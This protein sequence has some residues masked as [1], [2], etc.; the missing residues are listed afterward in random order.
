MEPDRK[1]ILNAEQ[2]SAAYCAGNA[3]V[4]AGAGSGKTM[5]LA[6]RYSWLVTERKIRV[7]EILA[8][9]FTKKAAAQMH[10]RIYLE[11]AEAARE[12]GG[13]KA[14]L[15]SRAL[16][17]F[18]QARI[19]T[20][21]SYCASIVR[22]A[23][24]RYGIRPDF[25]IDNER[26]QQL[27]LD[28]SLP[29]VIANR[30]HSAMER[31]YMRKSPMGIAKSIF[32]LA[33]SKC[34]C[35]G[36]S[37]G[38]PKKDVRAQFAAI[39]REWKRQSGA[40]MEKLDALAGA[41]QGNK[42]YH[43]DIGPILRQYEEG[44]AV[45]PGEKDLCAFFGQLAEAPHES[46][47]EWAESQPLRGAMIGLCH[48]LASLNDLPLTKGQRS[49]NP[50]KDLLKEFRLLFPG[51]SA[52]IVFCLQAG[53]IYSVLMLF[54]D[55]RRR[56]AAKKRAAGI[57]TFGDVAGL[58]GTILL[59]QPDIR[60]SEKEAFRAI[61]I[62][63]FQDNNALQKDLL[64]FLAEK[65]GV[66]GS[67][68]P[69]AGDLSPGKLFFVGDEKQSIYLFRGADVSVFRKLKD[70]LGGMELHLK[71]NYRSAPR[72]I[73][74]FN[75]IFGGCEFDPLGKSAAPAG[76][77][78]VFAPA[79][80]GLPS[81]EAAYAPL[82]AFKTQGG[83]L[84]LCILDKPG[85]E[86]GGARSA[87]S[88][89]GAAGENLGLLSPL[90]SEA[91]YVA[92]KIRALLEEKDES[93]GRKYMPGDIAILFRAR[94]PQPLFEKHLMLLG[95]PY[96]SEELNGFFYGGPVND[97]M[98]VLR[99]AAYPTDRLAYAQMLRSPFAGLSLQG[100]AACL[101]ACGGGA[102]EG[103]SACGSACGSAGGG[104]GGEGIPGPFGEEP[105]A[106]LGG[107]DREKYRSGQRIYRKILEMACSQSIS[108]LVSELWFGEGYRYETEWHPQ[109]AAFREMYDYLFHLAAQADES[110]AAGSAP[111]LSGLAAFTDYIQQLEQSSERLSDIGIPLER[112]SA[113]HLMTI[114]KSKG[115]EFPVVFLCCCDRSGRGN[116]SDDIFGAESGLTLN[117]PLPAECEGIK[118]IRRNYFWERSLA[119]EREKATAELR[120]LLYVGMTR[121][122]SELYLSGCLDLGKGGDGGQESAGES[123]ADFSGR[124]KRYISAQAQ[125]AAKSGAGDAIIDDGTFFGLCL[126]AL[127]ARIPEEGPGAGAA[128]FELEEIP[129]FAERDILSA[130][131]LGSR[132]SNDQKGLNGFFEA[133]RHY[134]GSASVLA[135]PHVAG[136]HF[137][138]TA[139]SMESAAGEMPPGSFAA[140]ARYSGANAFDVFAGVDR[141]LE[142]H[143][144]KRGEDG[145][146]FN[147]GS[148]GTIAH[149]CVEAHLDGKKAA[150]PP[151]LAGFLTI[152]EARAFLEAGRELASRFVLS[153]LGIIAKKSAGRKSEFPFRSLVRAGEG[154]FFFVNGVIDL[155]FEDAEA[156][157][158]VDF[159][160]DSSENPREHIAQMA[161]YYKAASDL[162]AVP[163]KK[164]CKI[165]LYYLRTGRA[166][167]VTEQA[168][169]HGFSGHG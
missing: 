26:C 141:M 99:L 169:E 70:E 52:L 145:E 113:V 157:H 147:Q 25:S 85:A 76:C 75:A 139:L 104:A 160:T 13:E 154:D 102:G 51:F 164:S 55:L 108:S 17:E 152:K 2:R 155:V 63:E 27:A 66:S 19:Q 119:A 116:S 88:G 151:K 150:I 168:R 11:L 62:D 122:E 80:P 107:E 110:G 56:Y 53:L 146:K 158:V 163:A 38:D 162:F 101:A 60:Q 37:P 46:A 114:H 97:L 112:H 6:A 137:S 89:S 57:L 161:C 94:S 149:I 72:L 9:T 166:V 131:T 91:R 83:K 42:K 134:Y 86:N 96:A 156:V 84:A 12:G 5:V 109:T 59:E 167:E 133:A 49:D 48:F 90:E 24:N 132:F 29:F 87:G 129:A 43:P 36:A 47:V 127:G 67:S 3:V 92:E 10:R 142:R 126:P 135:T 4:A 118:D 78:A 115:L 28:E 39:C 128:F 153:P 54:A 1:P 121:A 16:E 41:Y 124:L 44:L 45:F 140:S 77:P 40:V 144:K 105:V 79:S 20:L 61:M 82:E 34:D 8:L 148:F 93:G 7:P 18:A 58:A 111:S 165:W 98:S 64:F 123:G 103:G 130:E 14:K 30:G 74:A 100:L 73:G 68:V 31:L 21:D 69:S 35:S 33:L 159:K 65:P 138:P 81:F 120:R 95:I 117:P 106:W 136:K 125:K 23:A 32:A 71:T 22:Q 50:V 143:A 15:A